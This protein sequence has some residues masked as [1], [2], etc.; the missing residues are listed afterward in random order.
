M[1]WGPFAKIQETVYKVTWEQTYNMKA[2]LNFVSTIQRQEICT[3][4]L[5]ASF[6]F[7]IDCASQLFITLT[8]I[9]LIANLNIAKWFQCLRS[10]N[11]WFLISCEH[12]EQLF[13]RVLESFNLNLL[14]IISSNIFIICLVI[15]SHLLF[16]SCIVIL[17]FV[18]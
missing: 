7:N 18:Y 14:L 6:I 10:V 2:M 17:R 3:L 5:F 15:L 8:Y 4:N 12:I 11:R 16:W 13:Y 9:F 1:I